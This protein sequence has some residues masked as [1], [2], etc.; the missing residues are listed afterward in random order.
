[1]IPCLSILTCWF[2]PTG[3]FSPA[4][5]QTMTDSYLLAQRA[6]MRG[7]LQVIVLL[8]FSRWPTSPA[9]QARRA[10]TSPPTARLLHTPTTHSCWWFVTPRAM[11]GR[12]RRLRTGRSGEGIFWRTCKRSWGRY[13]GKTGGSRWMFGS[14]RLTRNGATFARKSASRAS[15]AIGFRPGCSFPM[16]GMRRKGGRRCFACIRRSRLARMNRRG[17]GRTRTWI[18]PRTGRARVCHPRSRL[19]EFRRIPARR[20]CDGIRQRLDESD[21]EQHPGG[22]CSYRAT[23]RRSR[24][25]RRDRPLAGRAQ[26]HLHG[27]LRAADQGDRLVMRLQRLPRLLP[28]R[29]RRLVAQWLHAPAPHA[30]RTGPAQGP[31]RFSRADRGPGASSVLHEFTI[32]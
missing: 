8:R 20:L 2:T 14:R 9:S 1:M 23:G 13:R 19:P 18:M 22:R 5:R 6:R 4:D 15:P 28:G 27:A 3:S 30:V 29:Y 21:L 24:T 7:V 26:R 25:D 12:S 17:W 31:F 32:A 16:A 11:S 10:L